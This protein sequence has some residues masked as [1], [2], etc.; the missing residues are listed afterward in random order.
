MLQ[1]LLWNYLALWVRTTARE[2]AGAD[3]V[4]NFTTGASGTRAG[5]NDWQP[6]LLGRCADW[7]ARI[8]MRAANDFQSPENYLPSSRVTACDNARIAGA[9]NKTIG[10]IR[11]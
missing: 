7:S 9:V 6:M 4:P 1:I 5:G 8:A 10:N 2:P 11:S 3:F